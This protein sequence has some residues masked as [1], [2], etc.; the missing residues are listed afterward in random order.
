MRL[1]M[2]DGEILSTDPDGIAAY[3][4]VPFRDWLKDIAHA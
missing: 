3:T 1:E 2:K 4:P